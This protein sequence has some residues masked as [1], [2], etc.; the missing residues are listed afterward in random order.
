[1]YGQGGWEAGQKTGYGEYFYKNGDVYKGQVSE[2]RVN[3][4]NNPSLCS[5]SSKKGN[6][7]DL[8][9]TPGLMEPLTPGTMWRIK[10]QGLVP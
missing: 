5:A 8:A 3:R 1:M 2:T 9:R 6:S 4:G 7:T 10:E